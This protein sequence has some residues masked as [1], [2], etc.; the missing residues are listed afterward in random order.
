VYRPRGLKRQL[1]FAL[2]LTALAAAAA[3]G[4]GGGG[5][6]LV[7]ARSPT[8]GP[9]T[10]TEYP[11]PTG[12]DIFSPGCPSGIATGADG[13]IWFLDQCGYP[14][15]EGRIDPYSHSIAQYPAA[16]ASPAPFVNC[17]QFLAAGP[18]G[19]LWGT[20]MCGTISQNL[21]GF[22]RLDP[23]THAVVQYP[24]TSAT[25]ACPEE[26]APGPDGRMWFALAWSNF[27][28]AIGAINIQ[29][30][31][32]SVFPLPALTCPSD[33]FGMTVG[34]DGAMW[35]GVFGS[36]CT[37][38]GYLGR[39]VPSTGT[40]T[41]FPIPGGTYSC[42]RGITTGPDHALWFTLACSP[43]AIGRYDPVKAAFTEYPVPTASGEPH[44][45][46]TGADGALWFAEWGAAKIGRITVSGSI[47]EY[48]IPTPSNPQAMTLGPD[49][50]VWFTEYT[51]NTIG[52]I[53]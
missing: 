21:G 28:G 27:I 36:N 49:G 1:G 45:I 16:L 3:C 25:S 51:A 39:I 11:I 29:T 8:A 31:A 19:G 43:A 50:A 7:P 18:D 35:F 24:N 37:S 46:I 13:G 14:A 4:G 42:P 52:R 48:T 2:L 47:T 34:P 6:H 10:V 53:K 44:A 40:I 30:G 9:V 26:I 20:F 38:Q 22:A 33:P 12:T 41:T 15:T 23:N 32:V 17:G 5:S